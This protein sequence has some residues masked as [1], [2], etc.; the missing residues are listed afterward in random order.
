MEETSMTVL[1]KTL[2]LTLPLSVLSAILIGRTIDKMNTLSLINQSFLTG[3][4]LL[5]IGSSLLV[6]RS[7][8]FDVFA[9][10][11]AKLKEFFF[12]KPKVL[13]SDFFALKSTL[14]AHLLWQLFVA[15]GLAVLAFSIV[16]TIS[17]YR[18]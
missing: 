10:G 4:L 3:L 9:M 15:L 6:I 5:L 11:F 12:R 18:V 1:K 17:Y 14:P 8:F 2:I 16:L 13:Q 7:G